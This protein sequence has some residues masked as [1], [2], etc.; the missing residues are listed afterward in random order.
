MHIEEHAADPTAS[1][2]IHGFDIDSVTNAPLQLTQ[3]A[4]LKTANIDAFQIVSDHGSL[5]R[6]TKTIKHVE[7]DNS[8]ADSETEVGIGTMRYCHTPAR[9]TIQETIVCWQPPLMYGYMIRNF[10]TLLP[11]HLG[12]V[13][14]EP[15]EDG[16]TLLTW[17]TYFYGKM[18]GGGFARITLGVILPD[19]VGNIAKHFGGHLLTARQV[20]DYLSARQPVK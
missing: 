7:I 14:T 12:L 2:V 17:R 20:P 8:Q 16:N 11:D 4:Y 3:Y 19:L 5:H 9:L 1:R 6:F 18:V 15:T 10:Q 13:V